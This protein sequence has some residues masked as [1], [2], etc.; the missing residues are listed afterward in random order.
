MRESISVAGDRLSGHA[1]MAD[2][3]MFFTG[4]TVGVFLVLG[5]LSIVA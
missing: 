2:A 4:L 1:L 3:T 5:A